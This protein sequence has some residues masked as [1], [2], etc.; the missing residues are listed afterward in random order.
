MERIIE[1]KSLVTAF[2]VFSLFILLVPSVV[3]YLP[4]R[5]SQTENS[6]D[7]APDSQSEQTAQTERTEIRKPA[8][9]SEV[10]ISDALTGD[11]TTF[12]MEEYMIGSVF[13][14]MPASFEIEALKAQAVLAHTYALKR[15]SIEQ[16]SPAP[17]LNGADLSTDFE[18]Y[19]PFYTTEQIRQMYGDSF[20]ESY[21]KVKK[22][23]DEV[24][25]DVLTYDGEPI[26]IA[27]HSISSGRTES[28]QSAW[29]IGVPYLISVDS[30]FDL[31][32]ELCEAKKEITKD[33][34]YARLSQAFTEADLTAE[35]EQ[36]LKISQTSENGYVTEILLGRNG[37]CISGTQLAAALNLNS[38]SFT[39]TYENDIFAF[40][41]KGGGHL[42]G[43]SQYGAEHL[44]QEGKS[45][46][47][48]LEYYFSGTQVISLKE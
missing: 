17:E 25:N 8:D 10:I 44:A 43:M 16:T 5:T 48:I 33:E 37:L 19:Q 46:D 12:T 31:E 28:A 11:L 32:N 40:T 6:T 30:S 34:L 14:Q 23:V 45:Y 13:A 15:R 24:L 9:I 4:D 36:W 39:V 42:V 20:E 29:G 35:P 7:S 26:V 18:K 47:E 27:F 41:T 38:P 21:E 1:M 2:I 22:A 3:L